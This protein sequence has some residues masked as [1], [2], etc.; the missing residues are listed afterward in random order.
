MSSVVFQK[1]HRS[2]NL[3]RDSPTVRILKGYIY[4]NRPL[5][6]ALDS[7]RVDLFVSAREG[8]ILVRPGE[9]FKL[10]VAPSGRSTFSAGPFIREYDIEDGFYP[11]EETKDGYV[12]TYR[13]PGSEVFVRE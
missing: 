9:D 12:F 1:Y 13:K 11:V 7:P 6:E 4:F 2:R 3:R 10:T 8:K 5:V